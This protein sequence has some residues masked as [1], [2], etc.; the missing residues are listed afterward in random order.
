[1]LQRFIETCGNS[2]KAKQILQNSK[3]T[4]IQWNSVEARE[5][6]CFLSWSWKT[7]VCM[8]VC[9]QSTRVDLEK[10]F[11]CVSH[12]YR[13]GVVQ[14]EG[15]YTCQWS[16][17]SGFPSDKLKDVAGKRKVQASLFWLP[18]KWKKMDK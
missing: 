13:V 1:M 5:T 16:N 11:N 10:A 18:V 9:L 7:G 15:D 3:K 14:G 4:E 17:T 2:H 8:G 12:S 6:M